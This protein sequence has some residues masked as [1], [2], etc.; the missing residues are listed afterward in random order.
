VSYRLSSRVVLVVDGDGGL[1]LAPR[2]HRDHAGHALEPAE[3]TRER[4]IKRERNMRSNKR[5]RE[6]KKVGVQALSLFNLSRTRYRWRLKFMSVRLA[7]TMATSILTVA[8]EY[9]SPRA[10][11]LLDHTPC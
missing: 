8:E 4:N 6:I 1:A 11:S 5:G 3:K 9:S 7:N 10:R 2:R